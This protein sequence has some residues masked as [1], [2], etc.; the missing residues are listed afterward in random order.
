M[1][2]LVCPNFLHLWKIFMESILGFGPRF[3]EGKQHYTDSEFKQI[4]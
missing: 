1:Y 4:N 2:K 3:R